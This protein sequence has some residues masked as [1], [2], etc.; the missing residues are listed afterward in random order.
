MNACSLVHCVMAR[1][2][3]G[4]ITERDHTSHEAVLHVDGTHVRI[5]HRNLAAGFH[6]PPYRNLNLRSPWIAFFARKFVRGEFTFAGD[7]AG[8]MVSHFL[9]ADERFAVWDAVHSLPDAVVQCERGVDRSRE[10]SSSIH[11]DARGTY[12][13]KRRKLAIETRD[14][15]SFSLHATFPPEVAQAFGS[16]DTQ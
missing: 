5:N 15:Q 7:V 4:Y 10:P 3:I 6:F 14:K 8:Y 13:Y 12:N 16:P 1:L 11:V 9:T 2:V